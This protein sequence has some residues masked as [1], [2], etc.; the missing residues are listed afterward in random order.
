VSED[1]SQADTVASGAEIDVEVEVTAD[2]NYRYAMLEDPIPAG[3][4][5]APNADEWGRFAVAYTEGGSGFARQG[6]RGNRGVLFFDDL[7]KGRTRLQYRLYA[8]TPGL[9]SVLPSIASLM[10]F[11]EIR[12]NSGLVRTR[13]GERAREP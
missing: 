9:Y 12:G 8:E 4:E 11:P 5:V 7:P 1:P 10:Y 13:I 6:G 2:A 3:C